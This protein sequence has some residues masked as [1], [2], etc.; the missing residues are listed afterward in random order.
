[1]MKN[2]ASRCYMWQSGR[3]VA[4]LAIV[5]AL[6]V[7]AASAQEGV[8]AAGDTYRSSSSMV[9]VSLG[10]PAFEYEA[11]SD[12]SLSQGIQQVF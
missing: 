3:M 9:S 11:S 8:V 12:V 1:M 6:W 2:T 4:L 5:L 7:Q 10:L